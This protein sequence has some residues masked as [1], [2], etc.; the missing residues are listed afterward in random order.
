MRE[1][2]LSRIKE[3]F[4]RVCQGEIAGLTPNST[5]VSELE[6]WGNETPVCRDEGAKPDDCT[7]SANC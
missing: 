7:I 5:D 6:R 3:T 2:K 1:D 4:L